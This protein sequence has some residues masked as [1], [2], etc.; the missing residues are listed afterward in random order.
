MAQFIGVYYIC[1]GT[2]CGSKMGFVRFQ[3]IFTYGNPGLLHS[4][5]WHLRVCL[6]PPDPLVHAAKPSRCYLA[7]QLH[8]NAMCDIGHETTE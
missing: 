5:E 7:P 3:G 1:S 6:I 2:T 4:A 8:D